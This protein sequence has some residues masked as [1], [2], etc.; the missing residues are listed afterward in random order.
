[1]EYNRIKDI[2]NEALN[3]LIAFSDSSDYLA[4]KPKQQFLDYKLKVLKQ[5][6]DIEHKREAF[7]RKGANKMFQVS[8][9]EMKR[10]LRE[11][12][13]R[14]RRELA[15]LRLLTELRGEKEV[16]PIENSVNCETCGHCYFDEANCSLCCQVYNLSFI[17]EE[18]YKQFCKC[19][20]NAYVPYEVSDKNAPNEAV[21][22]PTA[23]EVTE[24]EQVSE[25]AE[26]TEEQA[27]S[28]SEAKPE[29]QEKQPYFCKEC[30][31]CR[32]DENG[33]CYC[34]KYDVDLD[35]SDADSI[36]C[37]ERDGFFGESEE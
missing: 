25:P 34:D 28:P 7:I 2:Y 35:A 12:V 33:Q 32:I 26:T 23:D 13:K 11:K 17:S 10:E 22:E 8:L 5:R 3:E 14:R 20:C 21:D 1:M 30:S 18:M 24:A 36:C 9:K 29:T 6:I 16:T 19:Y 27:E 31:S 4:E 37:C 15:K